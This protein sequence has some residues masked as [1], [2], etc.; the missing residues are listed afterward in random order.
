MSLSTLLL[1]E[2][3]LQTNLRTRIWKEV[4]GMLHLC[5]APCIVRTER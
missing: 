2:N 1:R 5:K 4:C 3:L